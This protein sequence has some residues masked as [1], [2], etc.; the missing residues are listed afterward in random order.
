MIRLAVCSTRVAKAAC[1]ECREM[2]AIIGMEQSMSRAGDCY[3]N[4]MM[5]SLWSILKKELVHGTRFKT[6]EDARLAIFEWIEVCYQR[7]RIHSS[8]GYISPETLEAAARVG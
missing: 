6:R 5:E 7:T 2:L 8:L 4:A 3:D 1:C